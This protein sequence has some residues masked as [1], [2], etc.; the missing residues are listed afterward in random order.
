M[1]RSQSISLLAF[2]AG[3]AL[4]ACSEQ[5][6]PVSPAARLA[7]ARSSTEEPIARAATATFTTI[8]I[9]G[10][11]PFQTVLDINDEGVL[12]GRYLRGK[13]TY[14]YVRSTDGQF[15]TLEFP[16]AVFTVASGINN[17][18]DIVGHYSLATAPTVRH[19]YFRA[20]TG[21]FTSFDPPGSL[22]TNVLGISN[23]GDIVGRYLTADGRTHGFLLS[24]GQFTTIDY[25]GSIETDLWKINR[26][27][28]IAGAFRTPDGGT[29]LFLL[30]HGAFTAIDLP[31][32]VDISADKG[33]LNSR[34]N[35][36]GVYC[37]VAPC[38]LAPTGNHAFLLSGDELTTVDFPGSTS[39]VA[40]GINARRDIV[41]GYYDALGQAHGFLLSREEREEE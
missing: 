35:I 14:G 32:V 31:D 4:N 6:F 5:G 25:P 34:G 23:R 10:G 38:V 39:S 17:R 29:H 28:L 1:K 40:F 24:E 37:N 36:V 26:R 13:N 12:V 11:S 22:R 15:M 33:N 19:G 41:G 7:A 30:R 16:G 9:P 8:D 20:N 18:G 3:L 2:A 21:A 27:G